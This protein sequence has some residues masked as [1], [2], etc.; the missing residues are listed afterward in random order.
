MVISDQGLAFLQ[1]QEG[2]VSKAY[3]DLGGVWTIGSGFTMRS[4]LFAA[5]WQRSRQ[6]PLQ[7]GDTVSKT[8]NAKLLRQIADQ[9]FGRAVVEQMPNLSSSQLDGAISVCFN[10]G[11]GA[12]RWR[13]AGAL[14]QGRVREA[15]ALLR[16][17]YAQVNG[18]TIAGL[19][20]RRA[21]EADLIEFARYHPVGPPK[22]PDPV[23]RA[24]Q[25]QL[26][27][28]GYYRAAVDGLFGQQTAAAT[29]AFQ[30]A[31]S[32][33]TVD[34][35]LGPATLSALNRVFAAT[36]NGASSSLVGAVLAAT[37]GAASA[38]AAKPG[39]EIDAGLFAALLGAVAGAMPAV[40]RA[41]Y[42]LP[43]QFRRARQQINHLRNWLPWRR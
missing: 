10:L 19:V 34:G 24:A 43:Q 2:F 27:A 37:A 36:N 13:W 35:K 16:G 14:K 26:A 21:E 17:G 3:R 20:R 31:Q 41:R 12:L 22:V 33:M 1:R 8:E 5:Y 23:V 30:M 28:L 29:R 11:T 9:E 40:W 32:D 15:A 25:Q 18:K 6:H 7:A 4:R 39:S 38:G 42:D